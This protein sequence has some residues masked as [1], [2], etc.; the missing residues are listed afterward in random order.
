MRKLNL[1]TS[2]INCDNSLAEMSSKL[3]SKKS[4][5]ASFQLSGI[6]RVQ[7]ETNLT[8][9]L[10]NVERLE[11]SNRIRQGLHWKADERSHGEQVNGGRV[12][13]NQI[14]YGYTWNDEMI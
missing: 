12:N 3:R 6:F 13:H 8:K 1:T 7:S 4:T 2:S 5:I 11:K 10:A 9:I 14:K